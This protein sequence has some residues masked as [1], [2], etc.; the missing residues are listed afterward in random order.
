MKK[1]TVITVAL[2]VIS[3]LQGWTKEKFKSGSST[4]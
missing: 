2:L 4:C 3:I 1:K